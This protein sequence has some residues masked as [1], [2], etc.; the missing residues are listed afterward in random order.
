MRGDA[1]GRPKIP[2]RLR[3]LYGLIAGSGKHSR[4]F[5]EGIMTYPGKSPEQDRLHAD[6]EELERLGE[7]RRHQASVLWKPLSAGDK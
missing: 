2:E 4:L 3:G 6:C 5:S 7:I 1:S